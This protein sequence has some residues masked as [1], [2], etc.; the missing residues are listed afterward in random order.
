MVRAVPTTL[1]IS[2]MNFSIYFNGAADPPARPVLEIA[3]LLALAD[4]YLGARAPNGRLGA[5]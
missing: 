1:D 5:G 3:L 2:D 4:G